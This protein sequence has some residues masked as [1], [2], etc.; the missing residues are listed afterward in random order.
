MQQREQVI[1]GYRLSPQQRRFWRLQQDSQAY[2]AQCAV[3]IEGDLETEALEEAL[4]KII[5]K[6]DA[7][8]ATFASFPGLDAPIQFITENAPLPNRKVDLSG[9]EP[10]SIEIALDQLFKEEAR[11][12]DLKRGLP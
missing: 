1:E 5:R 2:N 9:Q 6:H 7:L 10:G 4:K 3:L 12:F 8:R 11:H